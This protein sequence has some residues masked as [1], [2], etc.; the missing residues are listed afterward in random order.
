MTVPS[1][2]NIRVSGD[3]AKSNRQK[4]RNLILLGLPA[5]ERDAMLKTPRANVMRP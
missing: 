3:H 2:L 1:K 5:K 4:L